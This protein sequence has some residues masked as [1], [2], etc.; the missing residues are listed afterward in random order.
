MDHAMP[1]IRLSAA[2]QQPAWE[3]LSQVQRVREVL[4]ARPPL[5]RPSDVHVLR[6]LLAAVAAGQSL[7]IQAGDCAEDP[8]ECTQEHVSRKTAALDVLAGALKM[9]GRKPV[10]RAGRIGGQFAKPRSSPVEKV[11]DLELPVFRGHL[12]NGPEPSPESRQPDPLRILTGYMAASD[13]MEHLGW[14]GSSRR[15]ANDPP[16]W[17]SHEALLLDYEVPMLRRDPSGA[18]VLGSTH[19]PWI[20][21]RTR[22]PDGPHV[23]LLAEVVNPVGCK[24]GPKT[25]PEELLA[26]CER[27]DPDR[28][29][30]RLTLIARMGA[31]TVTRALPPL[32]EAVRDAG[33]PAIWL[34]D[35]MH[36]N[37]VTTPGGRK[38]RLVPELMREVGGFVAAVEAAG[39]V[40]GGL[41]LETTPDDVVECVADENDFDELGERYTTLCDPRLT[42][43][44]AVS[45]ISAW[46]D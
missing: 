39:G 7:V 5:V 8:E 16:T 21:E 32:V 22:Q 38:T 12:V 43:W 46:G 14:R 9:V 35:P 1:D 29:P 23:A 4:A 31:G 26:L 10:L 24:V 41:H 45:V 20:G 42:L 40:A 2:L 3:D 18:L 11:G 19:W 13:I 37:T 44:Q 28:E 15:P 30:G 17:T 36:A 34:C 6:T 27:L 33:H 25:T